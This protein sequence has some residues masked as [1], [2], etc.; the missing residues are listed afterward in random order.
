MTSSI[1]YWYGYPYLLNF[2]VA[3]Y[4]D[5]FFP[6]TVFLF[7]DRIL[8]CCP[9]QSAIVIIVHFSLYFLGSS[10]PPA[11][12]SWVAGTTG[13]HQNAQLIF[14]FLVE[15]GFWHVAQAGLKILGSSNLP[16]LSSQSAGIT[17]IS[18]CIQ[19][20]CILLLMVQLSWDLPL[21]SFQREKLRFKEDN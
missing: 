17:G 2:T 9:D 16:A 5:G 21:A 20:I 10:N 15:V 1:R 12:A 18:H 11:S 13:V 3:V 6:P 7:R 4:D 8:L 14:A 19:P